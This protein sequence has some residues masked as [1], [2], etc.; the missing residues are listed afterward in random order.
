MTS[1]T[2]NGRQ[3]T[4]TTAWARGPRIRELKG[5]DLAFVLDRNHVGRVAFMGDGRIELLP[6][7]YVHVDGALVGRTGVGTKYL[8]WLTR[9]H[10]VFEVDESDGVFDWRSVVIRGTVT[11]LRPRGTEAE[12][13]SYSRAVQ[14]FRRLV[15]DA[16][17]ERDPTPYRSVLFAITPLSMT[18]KIASM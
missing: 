14:A 10:V 15:P 12:R 9:D 13:A 18:G 6:I 1:T 17:T 2:G 5:K 16:F 4:T 8:S 7:H 3:R 11:L